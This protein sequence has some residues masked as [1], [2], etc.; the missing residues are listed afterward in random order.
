LRQHWIH[1]RNARQEA[2]MT[3]SP[4]TGPLRLEL[5]AAADLCPGDV[6]VESVRGGSLGEDPFRWAPRVVSIR[7]D[8]SW[9]GTVRVRTDEGATTYGPGAA[10]LVRVAGGVS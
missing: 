5:R 4:T 2:D 7:A 10:V 3:S 1:V 9:P 6:F 8:A